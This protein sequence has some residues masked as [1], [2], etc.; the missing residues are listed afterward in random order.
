VI[1]IA[2]RCDF[3][4]IGFLMAMKLI[5]NSDGIRLRIYV[6]PRARRDAILGI[7]GDALRVGVTS[8]PVE[9]AA[10]RALKRFL[11]SVLAIS[12]SKVEIVSGRTSRHKTVKITGVSVDR[13]RTLLLRDEGEKEALTLKRSQ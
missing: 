11:A 6:R 8:P 4:K 9:G 10:N 5:Q 1:E 12:P 3:G 13:V 2:K 7:H